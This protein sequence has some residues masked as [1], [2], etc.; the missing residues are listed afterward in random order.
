ME[1]SDHFFLPSAPSGRSEAVNKWFWFAVVVLFV[2]AVTP[3]ET[4]VMPLTAFLDWVYASSSR[5]ESLREISGKFARSDR[6]EFL[7]ILVSSLLIPTKKILFLVSVFAL[8][9]PIASATR[10][11]FRFGEPEMLRR[12]MRKTMVVFGALVVL[13]IPFGLKSLGDNYGELSLAPFGA[14]ASLFSRRLLVPGLAESIG[15]SGYFYY[16]LFSMA[17]AFAVVMLLVL[18]FEL[19]G[20][21][22]DLIALISICTSSFVY[23]N[24]AFP[25]Y[26]DGMLVGFVLLLGVVPLDSRSRL[27][28]VALSLCT[29]ELSILMLAPLAI[30][31]FSKEERIQAFL[32]FLVYGLLFVLLNIPWMDRLIEN[33]RS[34]PPY[35]ISPVQYFSDNPG[36]L[37]GGVAIAFKLFW[38]V[39]IVAI[40]YAIR[41]EE[42]RIAW[43]IAAVILFPLASLPFALDTSRL[44]GWSFVALLIG[45]QYLINT[46]VLTQRSVRVLAVANL[47]VPSFYIGLNSGIISQPGLYDVILRYLGKL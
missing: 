4:A 43:A 1:K 45:L 22:L 8:V 42:V 33:H 34:F 17:I 5:T 7:N 11:L 12:L 19:S 18:W 35:G 44:M 9:L 13:V 46:G 31:F 47:L 29:H 27:G 32:V 28:V 39:P 26:V 40:L 24:F 16:F 10:A 6:T 41:N 3:F 15:L 36:L 30:L 14:P 2:V 38:V 20:I 25:G 21:Q 23:F 37:V